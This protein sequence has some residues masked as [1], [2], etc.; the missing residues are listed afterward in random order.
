MERYGRV[1]LRNC[2]SGGVA[3]VPEGRAEEGARL[4]VYQVP[5]TLVLQIMGLG[6]YFGLD[7][8]VRGEHC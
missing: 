3:D 1:S 8:R 2:G 7:S 6:R 5:G 4:I